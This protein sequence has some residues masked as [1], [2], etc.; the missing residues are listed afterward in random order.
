M[1]T[2][3]HTHTHRHPSTLQSYKCIMTDQ[4][5]LKMHVTGRYSP[6]YFPTRKG[7]AFLTHRLCLRSLDAD[8][9]VR[10]VSVLFVGHRVE[11]S[12]LCHS[13]PV[14]GASVI[15]LGAQIRQRTR[16]GSPVIPPLHMYLIK[17]LHSFSTL[18]CGGVL[19]QGESVG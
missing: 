10:Y 6:L 18:R 14:T 2:P 12:N 3:T 15:S 9:H 7:K 5:S 11:K 16:P 4:G 1:K 13:N 8:S 19:H 17:Q